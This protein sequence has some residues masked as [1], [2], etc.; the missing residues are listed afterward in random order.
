M[1]LKTWVLIADGARARIYEMEKPGAKLKPTK[2]EE[3]VGEHRYSR[4]IASDIQ[5]R[6]FDSGGQGRHAYEDPTDPHRHAKIEFA[7]EI[8]Q[9]LELER[10]RDSFQQLIVVA[11]PR[12]L[13]DLR[14]RFSDPLKKA[15]VAEVNKDLTK[16]PLPDLENQL[17]DT[18]KAARPPLQ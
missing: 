5:G 10:S 13:G 15:I 17:A 11:A 6:V 16:M 4:D 18:L 2:H 8:A 7:Q 9:L 3:V 12:T 14:H 1:P